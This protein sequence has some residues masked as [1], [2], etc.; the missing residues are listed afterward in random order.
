MTFSVKAL[1]HDQMA[2]IVSYCHTIGACKY[3]PTF[4]PGDYHIKTLKGD[5]MQMV[6]QHCLKNNLDFC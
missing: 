6:Y 5:E 2:T 3:G 4:N 1:S